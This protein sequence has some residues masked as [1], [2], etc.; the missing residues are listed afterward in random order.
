MVIMAKNNMTLRA[1]VIG[2]GKIAEEHLRF[3]KESD[4]TRLVGVCDLSKAMA[5]FA[6]NRFS[7]DGAFTNYCE[8]LKSTKVDVV[9]VL[10]PPHTHVKIAGDCLRA[11]AHVIVEKPITLALDEFEELWSLAEKHGVRLIEDHNYRFNKPIREMERMV[12]AGRIGEI[13]EVEVSMA[14]GIRGEGGRYADENLPHPSHQ[15]SA[16]VLHEFMT[17]W[18]YLLRRFM[19]R[20]DLVSAAWSNH[21]GG[22]LFKYD[23]LDAILIGGSVHGRIRFS[24][25]TWP[26][27][28]RVV[29]R[30][31][32]GTLETDLFQ[33]Y[34]GVWVPRGGPEQLTPVINQ[35]ANGVILKRAARRNLFQKI[36]QVTPYEGLRSFLEL[37]YDAL[38]SGDTLPVGYEDMVGALG[39]IEKLLDE[40]NRI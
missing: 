27:R 23:D 9:H 25:R 36:M 22:D 15:M 35:R 37:T 40:G 2:T 10:T 31:S 19:P 21:G 3:L 4:C 33:P 20:V 16:G 1:A 24:C 26:E 6:A 7:A 17:H 34:V 12:A 18:C 32:G 8:M 28:F 13:G 38:A 5:E 14:L 39:L 30:G 11:G 29:V